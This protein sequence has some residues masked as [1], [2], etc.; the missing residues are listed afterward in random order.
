MN[1]LKKK[2]EEKHLY[3][4]ADIGL[5]DFGHCRR[6]IKIVNVHLPIMLSILIASIL[7]C[8]FILIMFLVK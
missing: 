1:K 4:G 5:K 8:G 7:F 3:V 2:L 6:I